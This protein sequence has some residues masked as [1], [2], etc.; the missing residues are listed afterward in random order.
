MVLLNIF[1][2][3]EKSQKKKKSKEEGVGGNGFQKK[4]KIKKKVEKM[5]ICLSMRESTKNWWKR[6]KTEG[7]K[8]VEKKQNDVKGDK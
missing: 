7:E 6:Q 4:K 8:G 5:R 2:S 3:Q 1:G